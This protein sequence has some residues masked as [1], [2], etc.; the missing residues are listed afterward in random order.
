MDAKRFEYSATLERDG[1]IVAEGTSRVELGDPW[2]P[3]HLVLV[4]VAQCTLTSLRYYARRTSIEASAE[5]AGVVT[6]REEDG[7]YALVEI[8]V[9]LD[10]QLEPEPPAEEL[11]ELLARAER[12]CFV[13]NSLTAHPATV[14]RV[15]GELAEAAA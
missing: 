4:A 13:G 7:L 15:N 6:R 1:A 5:V 2:L 8:E 12:G 11:G 9:L 14:W 3:E 10:V